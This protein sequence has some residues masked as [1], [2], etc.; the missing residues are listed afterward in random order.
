VDPDGF[1]KWLNQLVTNAEKKLED[2]KK[3]GRP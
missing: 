1:T 3:A 2:E